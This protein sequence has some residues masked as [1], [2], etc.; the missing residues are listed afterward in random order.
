MINDVKEAR[1]ESAQSNS[2]IFVE[3]PEKTYRRTPQRSSVANGEREAA[4][5]GPGRKAF[6]THGRAGA[7]ALG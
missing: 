4:R 6:Q 3:K 7:K 5:P 2:G 1:G